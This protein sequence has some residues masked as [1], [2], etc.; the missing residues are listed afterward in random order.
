MKLEPMSS[1]PANS[2]P[3]THDPVRQGIGL[4]G[5]MRHVEIMWSAT[6]NG[7]VVVNMTTGERSKV[8]L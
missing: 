2:N 3:Y 6:D 5:S 1:I 8:V 4:G 7:L